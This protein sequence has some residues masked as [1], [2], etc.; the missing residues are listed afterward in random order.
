MAKHTP[1]PL[2]VVVKGHG[3]GIVGPATKAFPLGE[4]IAHMTSGRPNALAHAHLFA[5]APALYEALEAIASW[6]RNG[7]YDT[8][9][10]LIEMDRLASVAESALATAR[11]G[12]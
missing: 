5:A 8:R 6:L 9:G 10:G 12:E 7:D 2:T 4:H 3:I 11:Q 1:G